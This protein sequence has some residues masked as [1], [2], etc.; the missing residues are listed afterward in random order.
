MYRWK[1]SRD[2]SPRPNGARRI[3][4]SLALLLFCLFWALPGH[5]APAVR[6]LASHN[7][8]VFAESLDFAIEA[9]SDQVISDAV[10]FY[11]RV[12]E[13]LIYRL[14]RRVYP[15]FTP[16]K[17]VRISYSEALERGQYAPGTTFRIWWRLLLA[18][19]TVFETEPELLYYTD[20]NQEWQRLAGE[21]VDI[22]WYGEDAETA[23]RFLTAAEEALERLETQ[24]GVDVQQ[25]VSVYVYNSAKD[26][27][28]ATSQR[29]QG[30]DERVTT[31]GVAVDEDTLLLLGTH[32]DAEPTLAHE[33]SHIVVGLAT[34]NPYAD[35]PR[36]LDEG[37]AM[38]AEGELP[39][40]NAAALERAVRRDELL[41]VRSMSSYTGQAELVDLYY[42]EVYS[43]VDYL[44]R[45]FG[46]D[47]MTALLG[48]FAQGARQEDA[49]LQVYGFGLDELDA[50]WRASLGLAPRRATPTAPAASDV[51]ASEQPALC[52]SL[53]LV[54]LPLL[55]MLVVS[56][57]A[58]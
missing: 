43:I 32:R 10:L 36:W 13:G 19:G 31:L 38:Y 1:S 35:L 26:M 49:L 25:R 22:Y 6:V 14:V 50:R 53:A 46:R 7:D 34:D 39:P 30:Y 8:Y 44:L 3:G 48:V 18:D 58:R 11:G 27:A 15:A 54:T 28:L 29:G 2:W 20:T 52:G 9:A 55:G 42:G 41:S 45:T 5:A 51:A 47:K 16:G 4:W 37:L 40:D 33:L 23:E 21:R 24:I 57:A 17:E 56:R 12:G